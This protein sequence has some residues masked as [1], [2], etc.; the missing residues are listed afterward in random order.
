MESALRTYIIADTTVGGLIA[1]G[2]SPE[3]H[4]MYPGKMPQT[5][6]MPLLVYQRVSGPREHDMDGAAGIAN[7][8]IQIDA[9]ASTYTGAK[10]L[11]T[12]VRKRIDGYSGD[13]GSPAVDVIVAMLL[14]DRD[15]YD[16][17]TELWRVSMDFEIMHIEATT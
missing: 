12:A 6:T 4:R 9:W 11:S 14:S 13:V 16:D 15:L 7:P 10:A 8:R 5:P 1:I 2:T 17:E 3:I